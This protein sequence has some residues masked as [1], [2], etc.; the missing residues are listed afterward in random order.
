MSLPARRKSA[1]A[2]TLAFSI[3]NMNT[4]DQSTDFQ[5]TSLHVFESKKWWSEFRGELL[6]QKVTNAQGVKMMLQQFIQENESEIKTECESKLKRLSSTCSETEA[7]TTIG[8]VLSRMAMSIRGDGVRRTGSTSSQHSSLTKEDSWK[9]KAPGF[10]SLLTNPVDASTRTFFS[11]ESE[12][13]WSYLD[14]SYRNMDEYQNVIRGDTGIFSVHTIA[15]K[16]GDNERRRSSNTF[17]FGRKLSHSSI[18]SSGVSSTSL[19]SRLSENLSFAEVDPYVDDDDDRSVC[20]TVGDFYSAGED[21]YSSQYQ[22]DYAASIS[23]EDEIPPDEKEDED[24]DRSNN[25]E[26]EFPSESRRV[27]HAKVSA[28]S[29]SS[30]NGSQRSLRPTKEQMHPNEISDVTVLREVFG[31][32]DS[33]HSK[34]SLRRVPPSFYLDQMNEQTDSILPQPYKPSSRRRRRKSCNVKR[35]TSHDKSA[36]NHSSQ[37]AALEPNIVKQR[38]EIR[39]VEFRSPDDKTVVIDWG[40]SNALLDL[41]FE[42]T[43]D[44]SDSISSEYT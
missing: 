40:D 10:A 43:A 3:V 13:S 23:D 35:R 9:K 29:L 31:S 7:S 25:G 2:E 19:I 8:S 41:L 17:S 11:D 34:T 16:H 6:K 38:P 37:A 30:T 39:E 27:F 36:K 21:L 4:S 20:S 44:D 24:S 5:S 12:R 15:T 32:G 26:F 33:Q 22:A 18:D 28:G 1:P 42:K 14:E